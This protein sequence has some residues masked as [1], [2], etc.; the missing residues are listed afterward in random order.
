M[1]LRMLQ[2]LQWP[3]FIS[4]FFAGQLMN[5]WF[6]AEQVHQAELSAIELIQ[7]F[8][9]FGEVTH[10]FKHLVD[11][12]PRLLELMLPADRVFALLESRSVIEPNA[13]D[14]PLKRFVPVDG[15]I[16]FEIEGVDFAYPT[17]PEHR[18][19]R[20]LTLT[21]PAGKTVALVGERGCGKSTTVELLKRSYDPEAGCGR[22]L[23]NAQ[24]MQSIDVRSFRRH[25]S[26]VSQSVHLFGGS[27]KDNILYGL[28]PDERRERGFDSADDMARESAEKELRRVTEMAGC[29]FIDDY[30]LKLE[31]RLG[32]GGIKLSGGQKQCIAIARALIKRPALL[33]LDEATSR[34]WTARPR[35]SWLR[36][37]VRSRRAMASP[38]SKSPTASR[39]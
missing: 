7:L 34:L 3:T 24:P 14:T 25:I 23:V 13:G 16:S 20:G 9:T 12:L 11:Q 32:T 10:S 37:S 17:M 1:K 30:P 33:I 36:L 6:G 35:A 28:T 8:H 29:D 15:G 21:I 2:H 18:V 26:V 38:S 19:L 39:R 5:L 31:T 27:L 22:V 4:I